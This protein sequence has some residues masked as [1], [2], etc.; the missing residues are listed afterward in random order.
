MSQGDST[1]LFG[2]FP[3]QSRFST[4]ER[5]TLKTFARVLADRLA[6]GRSFTCLIT[7]DDELCRLNGA[8][9]GHEYPTDVLS[10]PASAANGDLGEMAV[11]AERAAAQ[12]AEFGHSRLDETRIL[13][14]HGL[15]H[16]LGM[17]HERDNGEM[18]AAEQRWRAEFGLPQTLITR[19]SHLG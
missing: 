15:L 8:F 2:A 12:A 6:A 9:L 13:M 4:E 5:R 14:L 16:L 18:E 17:D 10:F 3:A 1:V 11:S 7:G 19:A